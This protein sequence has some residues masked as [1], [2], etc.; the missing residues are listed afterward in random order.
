[1]HTIVFAEDSSVQG[2]MLRRILVEEGYTVFWG[3]NGAEAYELV[4]REKPSLIIT[5]ANCYQ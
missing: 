4:E 2:V 5:D 1:M 3:K